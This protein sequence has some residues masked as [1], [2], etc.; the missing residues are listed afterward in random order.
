MTSEEARLLILGVGNELR[1]D[2][3]AGLLV[4][5][6]LRAQAP[7][8]V[9]VREASGEGTALMSAWE[10][11]GQVWLVDAVHSGAAPGT[12]HRFVIEAGAPLPALPEDSLSS[13]GF[14]VA[15]ALA[16]AQALD[17]L[18]PRLVLF[19]IE[20]AHFDHGAPLSPSVSAAVKAVVAELLQ[21][22]AAASA[23]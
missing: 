1:G 17:R 11:A 12:I 13:H 16:L 2:D 5:R 18:P 21:E 19:G 4:A 10:G 20:G 6:R 8:G 14:G 22:L 7:S 9:A 23:T 15:A 3:A